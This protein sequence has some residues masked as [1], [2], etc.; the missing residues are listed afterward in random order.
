MLTRNELVTCAKSLI[1]Q[2]A[3]GKRDP[4]ARDA[5]LIDIA[6]FQYENVAA[7]RNIV[8][9]V[10][11][12]PHALTHPAEFPAVA[13]DVF[14]HARVASFENPHEVRVFTTSGTTQAQRGQHSFRDMELYD[15]AAKTAAD[16]ALFEEPHISKLI[17]LASPE[18][19]APH[20]S[21]S[22]MFA[23]FKDWYAPQRTTY[24]W[25]NQGLNAQTLVDALNEAI[26]T[27]TP[28]ALLGTSFAFVLAEEVLGAQCWSLPERSFVMQTG[29]FK[30]KSREVAPAT[31]K[32]M[33]QTRYGIAPQRLVAEYGMT[34]LSSQMYQLGLREANHPDH[35]WVP[36]WMRVSAVDPK[37]LRALPYGEVG[38]LRIDDVANVD[39]VCC[40]QTADLARVFE[41]GVELLGRSEGAIP[42]GCSL[43][44]EGLFSQSK[45]R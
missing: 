1:T 41:D 31:L 30:G 44:V 20:S 5:L 32:S 4:A 37:T 9:H 21:L 16:F 23:R 8:N 25:N 17:I 27:N 26:Q 11:V 39:S 6:R 13:T 28:V 10:G 22:Y 18:M 40:I 45:K 19:E 38:I 42:R 2:L 29:G 35:Y 43:Q 12:D 14:R 24:A 36:G 7:Y 15:L 33:L 3:G 34:E